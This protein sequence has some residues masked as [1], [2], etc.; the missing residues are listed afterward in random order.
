MADGT[1]VV[2]VGAGIAGV[3]CARELAAAGIPVEVRERAYVPGGRMAS[4]RF[5]GRPADIGAAYFTVSDPDFA[6]Q[7]DRWRE[8]GLVREW[9]DTFV[10]YGPDGRH[11]VS[12]PMRWAA[13][14][15]LRSL[16]ADLAT[17]LRVATSRLVFAVEP[18]PSVDGAPA[19][20]VVLAMPGPQAAWLLDPALVEATAV[21][22]R[23]VWLPALAGV[24]RYPRRSWADFAGAFVNEHPLL[25]LVCDDGARRGDGEPVLVAHTTAGFAGPHL[26][27]PTAAAADIENAV[28]ELLD[29]PDPAVTRT[30]TGGP[31][32]DPGP[33]RRAAAPATTWTTPGSGSPATRSASRGCRPPGPPAEGWAGRSPSGW[34]AADEPPPV[35]GSPIVPCRRPDG[36]RRV[37]GNG[38]VRR[39]G[40]GGAVGRPMSGAPA[41][42]PT[43]RCATR[44]CSTQM[45]PA[46]SRPPAPSLRPVS[47]PPSRS[48][49]PYPAPTS[50]C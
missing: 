28:R 43:S 38:E 34:P 48:W 18:G 21:A 32:P 23:Q 20:A 41:P 5:D 3:A 10:A 16:V 15:G 47:P 6:E 24:L 2:V 9:T 11:E 46:T 44:R 49:W 35:A 25:T 17:G 45:R 12:G 27:Q 26:A 40:H 36:A 39:H 8:A 29:L 22:Q 7:V 30:R 33:T 13:P 31:T 4:K 37:P 19:N 14:R 50:S 1:G 42:R